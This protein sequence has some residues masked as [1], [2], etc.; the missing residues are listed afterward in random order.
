VFG[1]SS[2]F[3]GHSDFF[4]SP[5]GRAARRGP[6]CGFCG[7]G[8]DIEPEIDLTLKEAQR[9]TSRSLSIALEE[10]GS[11]CGG[12]AKRGKKPSSKC[13]GC[14]C[15]TRLAQVSANIPSGAA[16]G[17]LFPPS[18]AERLRCSER[19]PH[20]LGVHLAGIAVIL[21]VCEKIKALQRELEHYRKR[22][23]GEQ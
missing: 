8:S 1:S 4:Q 11:E 16:D 14:G 17:G 13:G 22:P 6:G 12:S 9:G 19:L 23:G 18:A 5:F 3:G 15:Q 10:I 2:P 21:E 7:R 20:N